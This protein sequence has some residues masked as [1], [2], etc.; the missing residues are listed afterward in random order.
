MTVEITPDM[1]LGLSDAEIAEL[2]EG[3][4]PATVEALLDGSFD[5]PARDETLPIPDSPF[6]QARQLDAAFADREHLRLISDRLQAAIEDVEAG[7]NRKVIIEMPPRMGKTTLST[8]YTPLYILRKHPSWPIALVSHDAPLATSWGRQIRR[9]VEEYPLGIRIAKDAGAVKSW[10]TTEKG[11]VLSLSIKTSFTGKGAKVLVID[12]PHK[13]WVDAHSEKSREAVWDWWKSVASLRLEPPSLVIVIMTRWHEDDLVARLLSD[14]YEGD[15]ADW[16]VIR[17]PAISEG[18]DDALGRAEGEPMLSPL[19]DETRDEALTRWAAVRKAVG[20]YVWSALMQQRPSPAK[21][22]I[23]NNGWWRFWT[24]NPARA[25]DSD[26]TILLDPEVDLEHA[27]WLD[28]WD[29]AFKAEEDSDYVVGQR[30]ARKGPDRFLIFQ[31]RDRRT[32][33]DSVAHVKEWADPNTPPIGSALTHER[34]VEDKANGTAVIDTLKRQVSGL[35]PINPTDSKIGRARSV[36]PECESHNVFLPHPDDPG[37]EWVRDL[38]DE[39]RNFPH[40]AHDDQ[41]DGLSQALRRLRDEGV[42]VIAKPGGADGGA[43][44]LAGR[45]VGQVAMTTRRLTSTRVR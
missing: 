1:L 8:L 27:R 42:A 14:K 16:E 15:P 34:V 17:L 5:G 32:F 11:K 29:M 21:G 19:I 7:M 38:L 33:T 4:S 39:L 2:V 9:W 28:S 41:V 3:M 10:E 25:E 22:A 12:D 45:R 13:D 20:T 18:E 23:F 30:W 36:T 6:E 24:R 43:G 37:N 26:A 35:I 40:G 44:A 31:S